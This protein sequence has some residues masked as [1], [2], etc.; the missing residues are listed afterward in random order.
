M[1]AS[2]AGRS[3]Y[4]GLKSELENFDHVGTQSWGGL[5]QNT[6]TAFT[7]SQESH[8]TRPAVAGRTRHTVSGEGG[9]HVITVIEHH[10]QHRTT[11]TVLTR[12]VR[13]SLLQ[14]FL[15]FYCQSVVTGMVQFVSPGLQL[16]GELLTPLLCLM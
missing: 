9:T 16:G 14:S 5:G 13:L 8:I 12:S 2:P 3:H 6:H 15:H 1:E 10:H 11:N 7:A 4:V